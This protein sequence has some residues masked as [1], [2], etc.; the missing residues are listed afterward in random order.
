M[1][2]SP[3]T[4]DKASASWSPSTTSMS[5][6]AARRHTQDKLAM[7]A[8]VQAVEEHG[9]DLTDVLAAAQELVAEDSPPARARSSRR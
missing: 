4:G 8:A 6:A 3:A 7:T 5:G 1:N 2:I 9:L